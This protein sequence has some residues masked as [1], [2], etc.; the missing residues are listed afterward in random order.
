VKDLAMFRLFVQDG[1]LLEASGCFYGMGQQNFSDEA[2]SVFLGE[3]VQRKDPQMGIE[4][5]VST[6]VC[7][8]PKFITLP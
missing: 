1:V 4:K 5:K 8:P 2:D 6:A 7:H 3:A